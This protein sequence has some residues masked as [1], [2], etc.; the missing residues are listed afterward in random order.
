MGFQCSLS[1]VDLDTFFSVI[2]SVHRISKNRPFPQAGSEL[3][4]FWTSY[5]WYTYLHDWKVS[6]M[7]TPRAR[8]IYF[9]EE[10]GRTFPAA[11][12]KLH[13]MLLDPDQPAAIGRRL[14]WDQWHNP[15]GRL[16]GRGN[17]LASLEDITCVG[18]ASAWRE[19]KI[20]CGQ[21]TAFTKISNLCTDWYSKKWR[22][23]SK[24]VGETVIPK[25]TW[26]SE[27]Q[28]CI[29]TK[30]KQRVKQAQSNTSFERIKIV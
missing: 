1:L 6:F 3:A 26:T 15:W 27:K 14:L 23:F 30:H 17:S 10:Q 11:P 20:L 8:F 18:R 21:S 4:K 22:I 24:P 5:L 25:L 7:G 9:S 29:S 2:L 28:M 12:R 16:R 13:L 19:D